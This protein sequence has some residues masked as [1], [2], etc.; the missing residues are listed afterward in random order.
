MTDEPKKRIL[1]VDDDSD[2]R[3]MLYDL[4]T[5]E[6][7]DVVTFEKPMEAL[8]R[9]AEY[10]PDIIL[11]DLRMP[12][13]SGLDLLPMLKQ[14]AP[15]AGVIIVSA[16]GNW[17]FY[18]QARELGA[19]EMVTKPFCSKVMLDMIRKVDAQRAAA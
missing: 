3:V 10:A 1:V 11:L 18:V 16:Y 17:D 15:E 12:E 6:G 4:L 19:H 7:Y 8:A 5:S 2:I 9:T 14:A 13:I